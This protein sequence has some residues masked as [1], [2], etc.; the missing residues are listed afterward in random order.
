[1]RFSHASICCLTLLL[2][3]HLLAQDAASPHQSANPMGPA[4]NAG[5]PAP[6][7]SLHTVSRLVIVDVVVSNNGKPVHALN[8]DSFQIFEDG[9]EQ[10]VRIFEEHS[11]DDPSQVRKLPSLPAHTYSNF[12]ETTVTSAANVLLL[13]ALNTPARDQAYARQQ[14][15][16]YLKNVPIDARIAVFTLASR[17]RMVQGFTADSKVLLAAVSGKG[18]E[19]GQSALLA[20]PDDATMTKLNT[21]MQDLGASS[22]VMES[23]TQFQADQAAFQMDFRVGMTL[24]ALHEL[25]AYLGGIPGRKNLIWFSGSFPVNLDPDVTLSNEFS[26][27]RDYA[28]RL[29][30]TSDLLSANR[31]AL[32]P[33]DAR[34]LFPASMFNAGNPNANYSGVSHGTP[35]MPSNLMGRSAE[36]GRRERLSTNGPASNPNKFATDNANFVQTTAAEHATM[37]QIAQESGGEAFYDNNALKNAVGSAIENGENYYTLAYVP[38]DSNFDGRFRKIEVKLVNHNYRLAYREGYLA[39]EIPELGSNPPL[40]ASTTAIQRGAPPSSQIL[41]KVR[42]LASDNPELK[43]LKSQSGPAGLMADRLHGSL[44]R[45]W[46]DYAADMHQVAATIGADGLY[47]SSLEFVALAYDQDGKILNVANHTFKMNLQSAQ[48]ERVMQSGLPVH[49]EIDVPPGDVYLRLAVHDLATDRVGSIEIPLR[50]DDRAVT[51]R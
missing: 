9:K 48:Y 17:L 50:S 18:Q 11:A 26:P 43:G 39:K 40:N 45:Y 24:D 23:L 16:E 51:S 19:P 34:G 36:G 38:S 35:S 27:E 44:R 32:Y 4:R 20:D 28:G 21:G 37:Q 30:A 6:G 31:V 25:A 33:V 46:I 3:A 41:F 8:R 10:S 22:Q 42:V 5:V 49:Q 12:P 13:D 47:H 29:K 15:I 7:K 14:M 2:F 1:M